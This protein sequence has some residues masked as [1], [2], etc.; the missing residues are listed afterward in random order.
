MKID[1]NTSD[2][3]HTFNELYEH[4]TVLFAALVN[5][6]DLY[7]HAWKSKRHHDNTPMYD[8]YFIVGVHLPNVG[9]ITYHVEL[10]YWD[11]FKVDE[12]VIPPKWD[13]HTPSDVVDRLIE[14]CKMT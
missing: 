11:L 10:K 13:G 9:Q 2:G 4:R 12:C 7:I 3:Y 1:G 14:Y 8:G 5:T 6:S